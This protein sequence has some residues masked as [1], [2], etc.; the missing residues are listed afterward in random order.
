MNSGYWQVGIA[1]DDRKK[2]PLYSITVFSIYWHTPQIEWCIGGFSTE[3]RR[4]ADEIQ[5]EVCPFLSRQNRDI[6][7]YA[8]RTYRSFSTMAVVITRRWCD[9]NFENM[10]SFL[11][12][13]FLILTKSLSLGSS[14]YQDKQL[15]LSEVLNTRQA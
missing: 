6:L 12:M 1:E 7:G 2:Q 15:M 5:L 8:R 11:Q 3:N 9:V 4:P 10:V 13:L 14:K